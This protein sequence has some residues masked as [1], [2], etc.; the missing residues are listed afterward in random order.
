MQEISGS[1]GSTVQNSTSTD[2]EATYPYAGFPLSPQV[3]RFLAPLVV[4][5][6]K[7]IQRGDLLKRILDR[8]GQ[9]GGHP[10]T[11]DPVSQI[12]KCLSDMSRAGEA[13][14]LPA[15]GYWRI[16]AA[17][18]ENAAPV[19]AEA[20]DAPDLEISESFEVLH[21]SGDGGGVVYAYFFPN[22]R[23]GDA[24]FPMK[25]GYSDGSYQARIAA[26]LGASNPENPVIYRLVHTDAPRMAERYLHSALTLLGRWIDDAPG[27]EWFMTRPEEIDAL[28]RQVG[29][30]TGHETEPT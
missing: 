16:L 18:E 30:L 12:K 24:S 29:L 1:R 3:M 28:L 15:Y 11:A 21:Q 19:S 9:L 13:E 26:Q 4:P 7:P 8:H 25:I 10:S 2:A 20:I 23:R 22:Y 6:A 14:K 27:A 5:D 17:S